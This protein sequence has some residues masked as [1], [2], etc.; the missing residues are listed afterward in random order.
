MI[1]DESKTERYQM[2]WIIIKK[3]RIFKKHSLHI[4]ITPGDDLWKV[5]KH[6]EQFWWIHLPIP[7]WNQDTCQ[8]TWKDLNKII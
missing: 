5:R 7:T 3:Y 1:S 2:K 6:L 4:Q 8:E